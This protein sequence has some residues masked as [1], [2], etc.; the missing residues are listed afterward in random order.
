MFFLA[1]VFLLALFWVRLVEFLHK[2]KQIPVDVE[3]GI[4]P[5]TE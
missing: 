1:F 5:R 3:S 4:H 2:E